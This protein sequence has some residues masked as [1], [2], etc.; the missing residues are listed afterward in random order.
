MNKFKLG[1][2]L[3]DIITGFEGIATIREEHLSGCIHYN[4][5]EK[6]EKGKECRQMDINEDQ[7][8][9][10]GNGILKVKKVNKK[11]PMSYNSKIL[12]TNL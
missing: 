10:V 8:K 4:I 1:E 2:K 7:L 12:T 5:V 6:A 11:S 9:K 3:K